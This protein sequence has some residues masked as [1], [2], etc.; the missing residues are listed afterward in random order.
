MDYLEGALLG[1]I[2]SDTDYENRRHTGV[3]LW[4]S[5][6]FWLLTAALVLRMNRAGTLPWPGGSSFWFALTLL[7]V[8]VLPLLSR[9]YYRLPLIARFPVLAL[10]ALKY[11]TAL[12]AIWSWFVPS[13]RVDT[14]N[15]LPALLQFLDDTAGSFIERNTEM[16]QVFGLIA[17]SLLLVLLGIAVFLGALLILTS[18]PIL[19]LK[20][21][22]LAQALSDRLHVGAEALFHRLRYRIRHL[23]AN[24]PQRTEKE[25]VHEAS[26]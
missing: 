26:R 14:E 7:L 15:L 22:T 10:H 1:R 12:L 16:N 9:F 2:W 5:F 24:R 18:L 23:F 13:T 4:S 20:L 3:W 11:A 17:S 8:I 6:A 25:I 21:V 19:Y